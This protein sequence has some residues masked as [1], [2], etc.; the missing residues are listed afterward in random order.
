MERIVRSGFEYQVPRTP[1]DFARVWRDSP[2]RA[3]LVQEIQDYDREFPHDGQQREKVLAAR[4][5]TKGAR[6]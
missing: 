1:D 4:N 5:S 6:R 2:E 3:K